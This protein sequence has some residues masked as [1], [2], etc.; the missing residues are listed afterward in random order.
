MEGFFSPRRIDML[1]KLVETRERHKLVN[2]KELESIARVEAALLKGARDYFIKEGFIEV[3]AP[4]I[5]K[6]TGACENINTLFG[7]DYFGVQGY[8]SQTQQLYLEAMIPKLKKVW[9]IGPSFRAEPEADNRHLTEF[10]LLEIEFEG[11]FEELLRYIEG[12]ICNMVKEV[13]KEEEMLKEIGVNVERL[14]AVKAPFNRIT[15]DEAVKKLSDTGIKWGDDLKSSH[16]RI[17]VEMTGCQPLFITH[18][19][20]KIKFFNMRENEY[21]PEIVNSTDL[22]LP[23]SGE[24]VGAAER[25]HRYDKLKERLENSKMMEQLKIRGGNAEDFGWYLDCVKEHGIKLHSG[26]GIGLNRVTQFVLGTDDIR[27]CTVFPL[28]SETIM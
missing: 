27:K 11:N 8:L 28:N 26:C 5:T 13:L 1:E 17:L 4:H 20:K 22:I 2:T 25:E 21:R 15:Y 23:G 14:K 7:L 6:A 16:E 3:N 9:C 10:P 12:T 19:P 24:A 18:F